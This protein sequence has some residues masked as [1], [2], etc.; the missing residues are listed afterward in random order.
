[1]LRF[2]KLLNLK[3][4]VETRMKIVNMA[5]T[6]DEYI[7]SDEEKTDL[8]YRKVQLKKLQEEVVDIEEMSSGISIMD[9]G[10]NEF[11]LDLLEYVKTHPDIDKSPFGLHA[12]VP[13]SEEAPAGVIY[14]LKNRS[15]SVDKNHQNRLHPFYMVYIRN[16]GTVVC[17][18]LSPKEML[19][20]IRLLC[21]GKTQAIPEVYKVFNRETRD[22]KNMAEYSKLL[23]DAIAS[24]IEVKDESDVDAFLGGNQI[25]FINTKIKGLDDF[26]LICFLVVKD[27]PQKKSDSKEYRVVVAGSRN[28]NDYALL[29]REL[30]KLTGETLKLLHLMPS[31][32]PDTAKAAEE[33]KAILGNLRAIS[34]NLAALRNPYGSGHGKSAN[35]KGLS[36]R[37][38]KLAVGCSITLVSFLWD[39]FKARQE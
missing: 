31:N 11:R 19:D 29:S 35:Y 4:V 27:L 14:V 30:N 10:L 34:N 9:L 15:R 21:K 8:E 22:G 18:H 38:A 28:F 26:E 1:M 20:K 32:I 25:S 7:I 17:N 23:G 13:A 6:G 39:T 24:I 33:I 16:D 36:E 12:V 2:T 37:H 5:A 3:A